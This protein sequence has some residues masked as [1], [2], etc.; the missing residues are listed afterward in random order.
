M[1][2]CINPGSINKP[3][4]EVP[5]PTLKSLQLGYDVWGAYMSPVGDA[6]AKP[7]LA[8]AHHRVAMCRAACTTHQLVMTDD[9][10]AQQ[11]GYTRSLSVLQA[12]QQRLHKALYGQQQQQ[13][14]GRGQA[15][16]GAEQ[17]RL[18]LGYIP[19]PRRFPQCVA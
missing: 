6:Y 2:R 18:M 1:L 19:A 9:W 8:S 7:G 17:V 16:G 15:G 5:S 12:V 10:E 3:Q 13:Q 14:V 11:P 4:Q